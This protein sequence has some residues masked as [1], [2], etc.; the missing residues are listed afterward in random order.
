MPKAKTE[1][2]KEAR[3][4]RIETRA[5]IGDIAK[6]V[7]ASKSTISVWLHDIPLSDEEKR[8]RWVEGA[9]F[10]K[11][12]AAKETLSCAAC[13]TEFQRRSTRS[14]YCTV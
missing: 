8:Q 7:G 2:K 5:S 3:R 9:H 10:A 1:Q 12:L 14:R 11:E 6:Q 4:L 13:G